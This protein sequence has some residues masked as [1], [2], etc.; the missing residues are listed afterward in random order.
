MAKHTMRII[1]GMQPSQVDEMMTTYGLDMIQTKEGIVMFEGELEDLRHA[2]KH[3]V[4]VTIPPGPT[5]SEIKQ[6]VDKYDISLKQSDDGPQF[7]GTLY[8]INEAVNYIVDLMT[9]RLDL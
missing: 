2:T 4:D 1:S 9:E 8:E 6:T 7:H 3:V 5:V